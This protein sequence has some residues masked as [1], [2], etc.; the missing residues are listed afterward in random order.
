MTTLW[1][2]FQ[3]NWILRGRQLTESRIE[4]KSGRIENK[5][6]CSDI[7]AKE[8]TSWRPSNLAIWTEML[9]I[10]STM[11]IHLFQIST[12]KLWYRFIHWIERMI[13]ILVQIMTKKKKS[14]KFSLSLK[15]GLQ[16]A[17]IKLFIKYVRSSSS[18]RIHLIKLNW[19]ERK[20]KKYIET[21]THSVWCRYVYKRILYAFVRDGIESAWHQFECHIFSLRHRL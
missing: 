9:L 4:L 10:T 3:Q 2:K 6:N 14:F 21:K 11:T 19:N 7:L 17:L 16:C 20:K 5:K 13:D 12:L 18:N 1:I 8:N 15:F